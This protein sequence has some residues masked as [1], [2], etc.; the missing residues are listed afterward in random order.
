MVHYHCLKK[1]RRRC[2]GSFLS[3]LDQ[4][5]SPS[6]RYYNG[7][8]ELNICP[9]LSL[10]EQNFQCAECSAEL[11]GF[12]ESRLCDYT[13]Q[14]FCSLCHWGTAN[15]PSPARIIHNWDFSPRPM[16]Q[17]AVQYLQLV[18][19]RPLVNLVLTNPSLPAVVQEV[20]AIVRQR[21]QL[22][23]MKKYLLVCRIAGEEKRLLTLLQDRQHFVD[24]P[25]MF[26]LQDMIDINSGVLSQ[27]LQSKLDTFKQH[28]TSCMLCLAKSFVCEICTGQDKEC[29]FPFDE[30]V[31]VCGECEAVFHR[32]CFRSLLSCPRC[33]RKKEKREASSATKVFTVDIN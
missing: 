11:A 24:S 30:G 32:D 6:P 4:E 21:H 16:C 3:S 12:G 29:L 25:H 23:S 31:E 1:M 19:R 26:S 9:E 27:Y 28:I 20:A 8:L 2:V 22:L 17:A 5:E 7:Q 33:D 14:Y 18:M 13:G 15:L 10:A